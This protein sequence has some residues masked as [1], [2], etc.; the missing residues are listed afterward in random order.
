MR[1]PSH[2]L[3]YTLSPEL[4]FPHSSLKYRPSRHVIKSLGLGRRVIYLLCRTLGVSRALVGCAVCSGN[5]HSVPGVARTIRWTI[6][7]FGERAPAM[8]PP[9]FVPTLVAV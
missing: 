8:K 1:S 7:R 6:L 5:A 3:T 2:Y 4:I 9:F